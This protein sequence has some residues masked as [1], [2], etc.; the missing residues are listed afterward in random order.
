MCVWPEVGIDRSV[1]KMGWMELAGGCWQERL[2]SLWMDRT[3]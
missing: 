1:L 2:M 3:E